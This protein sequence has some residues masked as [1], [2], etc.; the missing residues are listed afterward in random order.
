MLTNITDLDNLINTFITP[1]QKQLNVLNQIKNLNIEYN[2]EV[3]KIGDK[4]ITYYDDC[5]ASGF[6]FDDNTGVLLYDVLSM[7][8]K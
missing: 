7:D 2:N 1:P 8:G 5:C 3:K 6:Y 4:L